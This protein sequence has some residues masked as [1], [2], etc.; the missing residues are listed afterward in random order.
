MNERCLSL[1]LVVTPGSVGDLKIGEPDIIRFVTGLLSAITSPH[2]RT[3]EI[4]TEN[5]RVFGIGILDIFFGLN[6]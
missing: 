1:T 3:K 2:G 5:F 4:E 6:N